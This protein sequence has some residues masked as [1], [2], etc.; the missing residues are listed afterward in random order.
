M[1]Q[2]LSYR[3]VGRAFREVK[4]I[5]WE[6]DYRPAA[7]KAIEDLLESQIGH[8]AACHLAEMAALDRPDRR[9]GTYERTL[10]TEVGAVTAPSLRSRHTPKS[11]NWPGCNGF[12]DNRPW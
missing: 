10:T 6:G 9:N 8:W 5:E 2:I 1:E 12:R 4:G 11:T 3:N 7:Q